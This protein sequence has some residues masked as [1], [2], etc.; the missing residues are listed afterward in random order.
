MTIPSK[1]YR[2][3]VTLEK[4][5]SSRDRHHFDVTDKS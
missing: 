5:K 3:V 4:I 2:P 1:G